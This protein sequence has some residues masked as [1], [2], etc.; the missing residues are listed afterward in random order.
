MDCVLL[1]QKHIDELSSFGIFVDTSG[2][3][4]QRQGRFRSEDSLVGNEL[5]PSITTTN[6]NNTFRVYPLQSLNSE[7][8]NLIPFRVLSQMIDPFLRTSLM[9]WLLP[10]AMISTTIL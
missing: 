8:N 9:R 3:F 6:R 7:C 1:I 5:R 10:L 2:R 4:L